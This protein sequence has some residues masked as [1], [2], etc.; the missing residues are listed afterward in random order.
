MIG[1][2]AVVTKDVPAYAVV[3]GNPARQEGWV[4][5]AGRK[6]VFDSQNMA[7]CPE[8]GETYKIINERIS[9]VD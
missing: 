9:P 4:S 6:L 8:N 7:V 3:R 5:K 2:G 1:A